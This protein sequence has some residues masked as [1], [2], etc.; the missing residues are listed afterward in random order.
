MVDHLTEFE[1][2]IKWLSWPSMIFGLFAPFQ[3]HHATIGIS[4]IGKVVRKAVANV[5][6]VLLLLTQVE[7]SAEHL[8]K[9]AKVF[10]FDFAVV[11]HFHHGIHLEVRQ[12]KVPKHVL[13]THLLYAFV[14]V[15]DQPGS[16]YD[17]AFFEPVVADVYVG[18]VSSPVYSVYVTLVS[19]VEIMIAG[20]EKE[21]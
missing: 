18:N 14:I 5:V 2:S 10:H 9:A 7:V 4:G 11:G 13:G 17:I 8:F 15:S 21:L 12:F 3:D 1:H 16:D 20:Y 6:D 19:V